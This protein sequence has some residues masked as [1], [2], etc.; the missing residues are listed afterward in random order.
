MGKVKRR[1]GGGETFRP[2]WIGTFRV[3]FVAGM[4]LEEEKVNSKNL[5]GKKENHTI[6]MGRTPMRKA[7]PYTF[8]R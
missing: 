7:F 8:A 1:Q 4:T 3:S 2:L 6:I 5:G